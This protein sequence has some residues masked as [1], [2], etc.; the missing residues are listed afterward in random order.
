MRYEQLIHGVVEG[1]GGL[2]NISFA[3]HCATRLRFRLA[4]ARA[5]NID[6]LKALKGVFGVRDVGGGEIQVVVG[7][8][9]E[10]I[11]QEFLTITGYSGAREEKSLS[12]DQHTG[13]LK[14]RMQ[15]LG[16]KT[17]DYLGAV[18]GTIIPIYMCCGMIMAFL[19]ICTTFLGVN[20][21]SGVVTIFNGV[22]N[23]GFYFM[24]ICLGW[25]A[26]DKLG[27]RPALG[28]LLG[29][30][31]LFSTINGVPGLDILGLPVYPVTY[32]G[33]FLPIMLGVPFMALVFNACKRV[34]P[35][36]V[37]YFLLPLCTMLISVPVVLIVIGPIGYVAGTGFSALFQFLVA[38]VRLLASALWGAFCPIGIIT[39]MDK[40]VYAINMPTMNAMG[41]DNIFCPGGLAGN[42][43][44]GGAALAMFLLTR[45]S[46]VKQLSLSSGITAILGITEPALYGICLEFGYPFLGATLGGAV[47]AVFGALFDLK[48]FSWA[49]PGLMTSPTYIGTDG[50]MFNFW[51][52]LATIA[53]SAT[54][55]FLFTQLLARRHAAAEHAQ[56][57]EPTMSIAAPISGRC[58]S[59]SEIAD[60]VFSSGALGEG[61]AI[62]PDSEVIESPVSG[63]VTA[64][65]QT[66]HAIGIT[67]AD[68]VE[69][70]IH[71]GID[72]VDMGGMGFNR[73]V[74]Q[75]DHVELGV[76]LI[77]FSKEL[78]RQSGHSDAVICTVVN[79]NELA[80]VDQVA[81]GKVQ[82][83]EKFLRIERS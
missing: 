41:Y 30:T 76:D 3:T 44:I 58:L 82:A 61:A 2:K 67:T 37:Q 68:G 21:E 46:E 27:V 32:S 45:K 56:N 62:E 81:Q 35:S 49:G 10:T 28:A 33:S 77:A 16:R 43:A 54:A 69:V 5:V 39:G 24:P 55:G 18:V 73:F 53:V 7:T 23:A 48:Q 72:T 47:G 13:S 19:T 1:V 31:L 12:T 15:V 26:A 83:G 20:A 14:E 4:D 74:E 25:A 52:C 75:G 78:I 63:E 22:A 6:G 36:S 59:L 80:S 57:T 79:S 40:A 29:M 66:N 65:T 17:M 8:D 50:S 71:I 9:I 11:F 64:T 60:S 42:S 38:H 70:F 34:I 51:M